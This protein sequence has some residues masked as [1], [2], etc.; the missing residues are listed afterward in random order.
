M[1]PA[2]SSSILCV[3]LVVLTLGVLRFQT[4]VAS[5]S[6]KYEGILVASFTSPVTSIQ[7]E[8][9]TLEARSVPY[10]EHRFGEAF[11]RSRYI[12]RTV[13]APSDHSFVL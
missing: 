3:E 4:S 9:L 10:A 7:V 6:K 2:S 13:P 5:E 1:C 8:G 12:Q 11:C